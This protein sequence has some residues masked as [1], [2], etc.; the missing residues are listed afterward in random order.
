M[1]RPYALAP[2]VTMVPLQRRMQTFIEKYYP[3]HNEL[4]ITAGM[5]GQ[6]STGSYHYGRTY[7]GSV[8]F[9]IDIGA[10]N[11]KTETMAKNQADMDLL[12]DWLFLHVWDLTCELIHCQP[13]NNHQTYVKN[14][15]KV[16]PYGPASTHVNHIHWAISEAL[17]AKA[18]ARMAAKVSPAPT[19]KGASPV[20][21][22]GWDISDF[23]YDRGLRPTHIAAAAAQGIKFLTHKAT[24]LSPGGLVVHEHFGSQIKAGRDS[25]IPF[26]GA[27]VVPR[28][29]VSAA[30]AAAEAIKF[31][32]AQ[33]PWILVTPVGFRRFFWQ[34]DT[35]KWGYD[36]VSPMLG[37]QLCVEL[38][39]QSGHSAVHY[40][41]AWAY[42]DTIPN[43][44]RV[45]WASS[46]GTNPAT[47]F[48]DAYALTGG[49]NAAEWHAYSGRVPRLL[50][51]GSRTIIGG[52]HTCDAN[53]FK[54]SE[55]D[56]AAMIGE[57]DMPLSPDDLEAI[58]KKV[59][60]WKPGW[61]NLLN[62]TPLGMLADVP[63]R[64]W[65]A[66]VIPVDPANTANPNWVAK[67]ALADARNKAAAAAGLTVD[68]IVTAVVAA[69]PAGTV[70]DLSDADLARIQ[71][72]VRA[73]FKAAGADPAPTP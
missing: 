36:S 12:A 57:I 32:K 18:E 65:D 1:V 26:L 52:M 44:K 64:V 48:K 45:L 31:V 14:Q 27:Y 24:E 73:V 58:A 33:A 39:K 60:T 53:A 4:Y 51:Y 15:V 69:L 29:G 71:G 42:G 59:W 47:G 62:E 23:D 9:A 54:G 21:L 30:S 11:D 2:G 49:D 68:K 20:T 3:A 16:G 41:P 10:Y 19:P 50:Q 43:V 37:E 66:D 34:V 17:L 40:A 46:Y 38:E 5:N 7:E 6:H 70:G 28:T 8:A 22:F 56:F 72:A 67:N 61:A 55:D 25:D 13:S 63:T 35:E